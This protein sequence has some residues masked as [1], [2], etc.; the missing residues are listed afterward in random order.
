M[1]ASVASGGASPLSNYD[2]ASTG[3]ADENVWIGVPIPNTAG[4]SSAGGGGFYASPASGTSLSSSWA[5]LSQHGLDLSPPA[6]SPLNLDFEQQSAHPFSNSH[7]L[8]ASDFFGDILFDQHLQQFNNALLFNNNQLSALASGLGQQQQQQQ[9]Q[10]LLTFDFDNPQPLQSDT[11][12]PP[13]NPA[14]LFKDDGSA[15]MFFTDGPGYV[16]PSPSHQ[17]H[18]PS[19]SLSPPPPASASP[20]SPIHVKREPSSSGSKA[21]SPMPIRKADGGVKKTKKKTTSTD[22]SSSSWSS[23]GT[24]S[25]FLIVTP[26]T[27]HAHGDRPNPY[28]CFDMMRQS[29]RGRK[30]PLAQDTKQSALQVRRLGA[31]FCCHAR[32]VK[33]DE[34]RPCRG[35][36]KLTTQV[37]EAVCWQFSQFIPILFPQF[38][39]GHFNK[40]EMSRFISENIEGFTVAGAVKP[41]TVELFSGPGFRTVL[42]LKAKFFTAKTTEVLQ[43]WHF[44]VAQNQVSL[45]ARGAAPIGLDTENP[46]YKDE[47][48][49]KTK[50]YI[51]AIVAEPNYAELVTDSLRHTTLPRQIMRIVQDYADRSGSPMV[52][53][54]LSLYAMHHVMAKHLCL[55][56]RTVASLGPTK[57]IPQNV[58]WVTPRVLNRQIKAT[59]D[60]MMQKEMQ[61]LFDNF[62]KSLKPKMR[63]EWAPCLA[64]FLVLCLFMESVETAADV[65]VV[66]ENEVHLQTNQPPRW[67]RS[68]ALEVNKEVEN[69]PFKQFAFQ[70]HQIYQTHSRDATAR[71]FN[72]IVDD[73]CFK[74]E[75][76]DRDALDMVRS[77]RDLLNNN[78]ELMVDSF[79]SPVLWGSANS[80]D[81]GGELDY[82][83]MDPIL[84]NE[85]KHP[86]PRDVA[87]NYTGKL[88]ARFLLS[89][90]DETYIF[91]RNAAS[92]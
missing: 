80:F 6:V 39:R 18:S 48:K 84:P 8:D 9:Q 78:C 44:T 28:E 16:S 50:E 60:D 38:I 73:L 29:Q 15:S 20:R 58:P 17:Q 57:L 40:D 42:S 53:K 62:N 68:F 85:E 55:T 19:I 79:R 23:L 52:K 35:C 21:T 14:N 4:P 43:Q 54:A 24:T 10:S 22:S 30:G 2:L 59:I 87:F 1:A 45:Q 46:T 83:V 51:R 37:P 91:G 31:C 86:Y 41:C 47:L 89:F 66:S 61:E 76:L 69:M 90:T 13:W 36:T 82:L 63:R 12:V 7:N 92:P 11:R 5:I 88:L 74:N 71:S 49:K 3:D 34:Q 56:Q 27:V 70:F 81:S 64:A 32:K 33:C 72:P 77:M 26:D 65:F 75:E 67:K 25:K